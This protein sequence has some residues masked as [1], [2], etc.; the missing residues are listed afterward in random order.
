MQCPYKIALHI[1]QCNMPL[2]NAQIA[3]PFLIAQI[4][5]ISAQVCLPPVPVRLYSMGI[6]GIEDLV[7]KGH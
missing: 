3:L 6:L 2:H 7:P 1:A 4:A 5:K